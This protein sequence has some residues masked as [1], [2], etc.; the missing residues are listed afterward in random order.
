MYYIKNTLKGI[1]KYSYVHCK[2]YTNGNVPDK[3]NSYVI[4][5]PNISTNIVDLI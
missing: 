1:H 5:I 2:Y 4:N 3:E